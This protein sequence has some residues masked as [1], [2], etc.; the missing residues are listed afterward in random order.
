MS[1][2]GATVMTTNDCVSEYKRLVGNI[3][4][5]DV[6]FEKMLNDISLKTDDVKTDSKKQFAVAVAAMTAMALGV[7]F[8]LDSKKKG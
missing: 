3:R 2:K 1:L 6:Q 7:K 8:M 4:M 5:Q